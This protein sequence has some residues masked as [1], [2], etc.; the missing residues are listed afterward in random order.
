MAQLDAGWIS[1]MLAANA[2]LQ[3]PV[4]FATA[5]DRDSH[6]GANPDRVEL[7]E[8]VLLVDAAVH[9]IVEELARV[10]ARNSI[11]HLRAIVGAEGEEL[12]HR[13]DLTA[14]AAPARAL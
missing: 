8:R 13:A 6:Q 9:V 12:P 7:L 3:F 14:G 4:Y 10:V 1:A 5:L 2:D 11:R